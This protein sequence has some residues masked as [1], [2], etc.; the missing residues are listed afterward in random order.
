MTTEMLPLSCRALAFQQPW[1][2]V[3]LD[4]SVPVANCNSRRIKLL[5]MLQRP[6][7]FPNDPAGI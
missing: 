4:E 5:G 6:D 7:L 2:E 3:L 1:P